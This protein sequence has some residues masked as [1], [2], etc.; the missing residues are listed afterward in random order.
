MDASSRLHASS[1][2]TDVTLLWYRVLY[3]K[4]VVNLGR[5]RIH[6]H[7]CVIP[8]TGNEYTAIP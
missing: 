1:S 4:R 8:A 3:T 2:L 6:A 7:S 5:K